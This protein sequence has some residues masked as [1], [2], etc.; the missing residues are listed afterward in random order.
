MYTETNPIDS[1]KERAQVFVVEN[2]RALYAPFLAH[3]EEFCQ[4]EHVLL[5][6][7]LSIVL[8]TSSRDTP[9]GASNHKLTKD[10]FV[11]DLY[12]SDAYALAKKL[13]DELIHVRSP[14]IPAR[15]VALQTNIK[16][17]EFTMYVNTRVLLRIFAME[18]YRG[19]DLSKL[20]G[21]AIVAGSLTGLTIPSIAPEMHLIHIYRQLYSPHAIADIVS[22]LTLEAS[23]HTIMQRGVVIGGTD[24]KLKYIDKIIAHIDTSA[25]TVFIG[26]FA[27][28]GDKSRL[29]VITDDVH[30][31]QMAISRIIPRTQNVKYALGIVSDF[32]LTKHTVYINTGPGIQT[33]IIDIFNSAAYEMIPWQQREHRVAGPW[34]ILRFLFIDIWILKMVGAIGGNSHAYKQKIEHILSLVNLV[35]ASAITDLPATFQL[36]NYIGIYM[37]ESVAKKKMI[38]ESGDRFPTYYPAK[39][40]KTGGAG[41]RR[42]TDN[43]WKRKN[44]SDGT[45]HYYKDYAD[46]SDAPLGITSGTEP[47]NTNVVR[48][49]SQPIDLSMYIADKRKILTK[50][51]GDPRKDM[52]DVLARYREHALGATKWS[53]NKSVEKEITKNSQFFAFAPP[54]PRVFL[55]IGCGSGIVLA[56]FKQQYNIETVYGADIE[57][58]RTNPDASEFVL[59]T[60][61]SPIDLPDASVDIITMFHV[62][63]HMTDSPMDRFRDIA[64]LLKP[65]GVFM[66]KDHD[67]QN[68]RVASNVDFE[69]FVYLV[70][71]VDKPI[72]ELMSNFP[73]EL[74]MTYYSAND[75]AG[76]AVDAGLKQCMFGKPYGMS[77]IYHCAWLRDST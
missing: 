45:K 22:N 9:L 54:A 53:A 28:R 11:W 46:T 23:L 5:G 14:H 49:T 18:R 70:G 71:E 39:K 52:L 37:N 72:S 1:I 60:P 59:V 67:V 68:V 74:P 40:T 7:D 12:A 56:A 3:V 26:P 61:G 73:T 6:G 34:V 4:R 65:G 2:D 48:L 20:A 29:Q 41:E 57:D 50:I 63:H 75:V 16:H 21:G 47:N 58:T 13:A 31:L 62:I 42:Y 36:D 15:T 38:K 30:A 44:N 27:V 8:L 55:D 32:Q 17:R 10:Q 76:M 25:S 64:R 77:A 33:H 69:H 24:E 43:Q 35:R 19:A 51:A 66:F